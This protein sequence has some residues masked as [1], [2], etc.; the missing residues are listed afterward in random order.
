MADRLIKGQVTNAQN[1]EC[2]YVLRNENQKLKDK[3]SEMHLEN[4][5]NLENERKQLNEQCLNTNEIEIL[6][7]K[8][9]ML[10]EV[11]LLSFFFFS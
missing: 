11:F 6:T 9:N 5:K 2:I 1:A 10:L 7:D 8:V 3:I 4:E